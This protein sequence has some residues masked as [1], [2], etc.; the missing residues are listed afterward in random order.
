MNED[1]T[2][3]LEEALPPL[4]TSQ[5]VAA[6]TN[7]GERT[8]WRHS[9]AGTMPSPVRIGGSIR[10]RRDEVLQW[11]GNGC[12]RIERGKEGRHGS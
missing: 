4:L 6:L 1:C 9:R 5:Q 7:L 11:I 10:F 12:P 3:K 2:P 8:V